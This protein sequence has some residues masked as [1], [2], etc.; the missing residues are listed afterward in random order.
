[1]CKKWMV[2]IGIVLLLVSC[3]YIPDIVPPVQKP[4]SMATEEEAVEIVRQALEK[5]ILCD[6]LYQM[7]FEPDRSNMKID[8][9]LPID[10]EASSLYGDVDPRQF[11]SM[12]D[13]H[14]YFLDTF[15]HST[16]DCLYQGMKQREMLCK[17]IN[18]KIYINPNGA[19]AAFPPIKWLAET[20]E[21]IE[22]TPEQITARLQT[23][24]L[25][26]DNGL[27]TLVLI[28]EQG[29]W[30]LT[31][32]YLLP[33]SEQQPPSFDPN[34]LEAMSRL[35]QPL[36]RGANLYSKSWSSAR[37]L[38][39]DDLVNFCAANNLLNLPQD[40][41]QC[42]L[43]GF[44]YPQAE[45]VE[46]ALQKYFDIDEAFL[47]NSQQYDPKTNTYQLI[48][49]F[50]SLCS[51]VALS[52]K[53]EEQLLLIEVGV[54]YEMN[55]ITPL[56]NDHIVTKDGVL[57]PFGSLQIEMLGDSLYRFHSYSLREHI[58]G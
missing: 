4:I 30:L 53:Q 17:E 13:I 37:E 41:E 23:C 43:P 52:A 55:Q 16:A 36:F 54:L 28:R 25:G 11:Q 2:L 48:G 20:I 39:P 44:D 8:G 3:N 9:M 31:S 46:A 14:R 34:D 6:Q 45:Q 5:A 32:S 29:K 50:G 57:V 40:F 15:E 27:Q 51:G 47:R 18:G 19:G 21:L 33:A 12:E 24:F 10:Y 49:G 58:V 42:Y 7:N 26:M 56:S 22:V 1:M 38:S 35:V